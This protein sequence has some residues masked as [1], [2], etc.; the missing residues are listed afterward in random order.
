M[1]RAAL[2]PLLA[3]L[4]NAQDGGSGYPGRRLTQAPE[5]K[6]R[7]I[8]RLPTPTCTNPKS[9]ETCG[10]PIT[11]SKTG[12]D[13]RYWLSSKHFT[14]LFEQGP[15][16]VSQIA[17]PISLPPAM[18]AYVGAWAVAMKIETPAGA[19]RIET[20]DPKTLLNDMA[21]PSTDEALTTLRLSVDGKQLVAGAHAIST[22]DNFTFANV[23]TNRLVKDKIGSGCVEQI[24]IKARGLHIRVQSSKANKFANEE[25]QV[26][27]LHLD[28]AFVTYDEPS[29]RGALPEMWGLQP[30]SKQTKLLLNKRTAEDFPFP[31]EDA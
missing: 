24:D 20:V 3:T 8:N 7:P 2:L 22:P 30:I 10:D 16:T 21:P 6:G 23:T 26:Y 4:V 31:I 18:E 25:Q 1:L 29:V 13:Y 12:E 14:P 17:G 28:T 19:I 9:S 15:V 11:T 27:G 5:L